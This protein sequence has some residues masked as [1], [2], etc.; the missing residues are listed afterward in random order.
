MR[1]LV[2]QHV[3]GRH[4]NDSRRRECSRPR[5]RVERPR[6]SGAAER[7]LGGLKTALL[8]VLVGGLATALI[9]LVPY[10]ESDAG[11]SSAQ[12]HD[13]VEASAPA[14]PSLREG[15]V[16][17]ELTE[18]YEYIVAEGETLSEIAD[19][20]AIDYELLADANALRNPHTISVGQRILIPAPDSRELVA[21][22]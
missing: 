19:R 4:R 13:F 1:I 6:R 14:L 18:D 15:L 21:E 10:L 17:F 20:F 8:I 2:D 22:Q 9:V 12:S 5:I 11:S 3:S 7:L 16:D